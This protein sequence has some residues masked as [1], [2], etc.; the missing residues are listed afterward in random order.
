MADNNNIIF[1]HKDIAIFKLLVDSNLYSDKIRTRILALLTFYQ[2]QNVPATYAMLKSEYDIDFSETSIYNVLKTY[3]TN[4]IEGVIGG[5]VPL[6]LDKTY[7][8]I[9]KSFQEAIDKARASNEK[10]SQ[11]SHIFSKIGYFSVI[12]AEKFSFLKKRF[13]KIFIFQQSC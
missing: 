7:D 6:K 13:C 12:S 2:L 8:C 3:K 5:K 10:Y 9:K 1:T 11:I 4:G